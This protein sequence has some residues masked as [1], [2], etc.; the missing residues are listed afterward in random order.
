MESELGKPP[1][2]R[3]KYFLARQIDKRGK[4]GENVTPQQAAILATLMWMEQ[5]GTVSLNQT[6]LCSLLDVLDTRMTLVV[7]ELEN[8]QLIKK[9]EL[10]TQKGN[11]YQITGEGRYAAARFAEEVLGIPKEIE[12]RLGERSDYVSTM[13]ISD[14]YIDDFLSKHLIVRRTT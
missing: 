3:L 5:H 14:K 10:N 13:G 12:D 11:W 9:D 4:Q 6:M 1:L 8:L 7:G 2:V